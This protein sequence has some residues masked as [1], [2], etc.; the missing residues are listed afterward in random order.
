MLDAEKSR[1]VFF[2]VI[3]LLI[4]LSPLF[5]NGYS[6]ADDVSLGEHMS[7]LRA[8]IVETSGEVQ[9]QYDADS[10]SYEEVNNCVGRLNNTIQ[11]YNSYLDVIDPSEVTKYDLKHLPEL[12]VSVKIKEKPTVIVG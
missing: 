1:I 2:G 10:L 8:D 6:T 4:I 3:F 5:F 12:Y 11:S 7:I 9:H